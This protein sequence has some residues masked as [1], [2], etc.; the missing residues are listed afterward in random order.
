VLNN[1]LTFIL[2]LSLLLVVSGCAI[3]KAREEVE[4]VAQVA[5]IA[6]S[7]PECI[8]IGVDPWVG[9]APLVVAE[10]KG[11]FED[12]GL[13]VKVVIFPSMSARYNAFMAGNV[14]FSVGNAGDYALQAAKEY[15]ITIIMEIDVDNSGL[16]MIKDEFK[17]LSELK[18]RIIAC[19]MD[20]LEHF[21]LEKALERYGLTTND[22]TVVNMT[23]EESIVAFMKDTVDAVVNWEQPLVDEAIKE[24]KGKVVMTSR[25]FP[26]IFTDVICVRNELLKENPEAVIKVL[27]C[28]FR[29]L[30]WREEHQ[31]EYYEI[32]NEKLFYRYKETKEY[33]MYSQSF[34]KQLKPEEIKKAMEDEGHLYEHCQETLGFYYDQ[35]LIDS[36]PDP[37]SFIDNELYL[38]AL[39]A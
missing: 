10:E 25:D 19:E 34:I 20:S 32:A 6:L 15:P 11:F 24:G 39:D 35:G 18:G 3:L 7:P 37:D 28:W 12:E 33:L 36:R 22:V 2:T 17:D 8:I 23:S 9:W 30:K 13:D 21:F 31:D 38:E 26:G 29:G 4:D 5:E 16:I 1:I 14:Q 27:R